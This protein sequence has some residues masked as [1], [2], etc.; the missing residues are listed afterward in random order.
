MAYASLTI[1][2]T[3]QQ[4]PAGWAEIEY[5]S[6]SVPYVGTDSSVASTTGFPMS[7]NGV[8]TNATGNQTA[9]LVTASGT[10][11]VRWISI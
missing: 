9:W 4:V 3:P 7:L 5:V 10:A 8:M 2:T 1:T 6:G 11:D